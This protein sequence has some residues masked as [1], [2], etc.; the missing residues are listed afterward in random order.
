MR[1][2]AAPFYVAGIALIL[3]GVW[4]EWLGS[5]MEKKS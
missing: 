4:I 1:F 2:I 3:F 5:W